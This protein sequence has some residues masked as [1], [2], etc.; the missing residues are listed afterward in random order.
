MTIKS[1]SEAVTA[2]P[3]AVC[4]SLARDA[5]YE[6]LAPLENELA[7]CLASLRND[8]DTGAR[9]H[10]RRIVVAVR[11][12]ALEYNKMFAEAAGTKAGAA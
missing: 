2:D 10:L 4:D 5:V 1:L 12:A 7:A 11:S 3:G 9:Y 6:A 8:D